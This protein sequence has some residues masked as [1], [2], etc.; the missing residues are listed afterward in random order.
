MAQNVLSSD[1]QSRTAISPACI[2][3]APPTC[4]RTGTNKKMCREKVE[5]YILG[6]GDGHRPAAK[7]EKT[8]PQQPGFKNT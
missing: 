5:K 8:S 7:M 6:T 1:M 3:S 2:A 4:K